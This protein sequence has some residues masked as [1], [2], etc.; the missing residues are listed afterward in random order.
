[1][2]SGLAGADTEKVI[3]RARELYQDWD[4]TGLPVYLRRNSLDYYYLSVWP[5]LRHLHPAAGLDLPG[6]PPRVG[7]AYVHVPFCSG[8]CDFCSYFLTT[9]GDAGS[10]P[11]VDR[12]LDQLLDQVRIHRRDMDIALS[13]IYIGGGTPSILTPAQLARL[14][15]TMRELGIFTDG[16]VGTMELHPEL[17]GDPERLDRTLEV[18]SGHGIQ[19]VSVGYQ[20]NDEALLDATNRRH[21]ADFL[22]SAAQHL[23]SHGFVFNLDLMYGLP[24]QSVQAWADSLATAISVR[25]DSISTYFTFVDYAT[26]MYRQVRR[27]PTLLAGPEH[28]QLCHVVAQVALADA[29]YDELPNDFYSV[30]AGDP[31]HYVQDALPS[32]GSSLALGAGAYGYY[33]GVQYFNEMSFAGYGRA[34][35]ENRAPV[36]RAAVLTDAEELARDIMFSLKNAPLLSLPLF[37]ER[38]GTDPIAAYPRQFDDL[39]RLGLVAVADDTVRLTAK[40]RLVVEEIACLFAPDRPEGAVGSRVEQNLVRKHHFAPTFRA[41]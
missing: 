11:R 32:Q 19:R 37:R 20:S 21:H 29:G 22:P 41:G 3:A 7:Q 40:G 14:L 18:L 38:H 26:P 13:T 36:W 17:F 27:D 34:I 30:P 24:G 39:A 15:G 23:R 16:L 10:D 28:A 1:V 31:R 25:P 8:V 35:A 5:G 6:R 9:T 4:V 2:D 12:Y 33:P